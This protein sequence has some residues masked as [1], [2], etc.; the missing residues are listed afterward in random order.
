[1]ALAVRNTGKLGTQPLTSALW[2]VTKPRVVLMLTLEGV[3]GALLAAGRAWQEHLPGLVVAAV[4][5]WLASAG[6]EAVTNVVDRDID[7]QMSRTRTRVLAA[8]RLL[9]ATALGWGGLLILTALSIALRSGLWT[10]VWV[11]GG[12]V[13]N[14]VVYSLLAKRRTPWS[15]V[16]GAFSGGAP[17]LIGYCAVAGRVGWPGFDLALLVML[18]T[19]VHVWSLAWRH[20]EDYRRAGVPMVPVVWNAA[21]AAAC[22]GGATALLLAGSLWAC[23][24]VSGALGLAAA[25]LIGAGLA[26]TAL[27][28]WLGRDAPSAWTHFHSANLYLVVLMAILVAGRIG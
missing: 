10:F 27:R 25:S 28:L 7:A 19:P 22:I 13:D 21:L 17:A 16:L 11:L 9:P 6:A 8:G 26:L 1:M 4:I 23:L 14:I 5:V 20:R 24:E 18:W 2:E 3:A 15:P 12:L